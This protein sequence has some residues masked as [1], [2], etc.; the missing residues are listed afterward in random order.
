MTVITLSPELEQILRRSVPGAPEMGLGIEPGLSG[1]VIKELNICVQQQEL[2]NNA[3]VLLVP[4][5]IRSTLARQL[6]SLASI[7][8]IL[9]YNEVSDSKNIK[10]QLN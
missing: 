10:R 4:A 7:L 3:S 2:A 9:T 8:H 1:Q 6:R 5:G